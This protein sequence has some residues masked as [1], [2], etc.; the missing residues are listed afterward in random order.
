MKDYELGWAMQYIDKLK[1]K[2]AELEFDPNQ[3]RDENGMWTDTGGGGAAGGAGKYSPDNTVSV[4]RGDLSRKQKADLSKNFGL[5]DKNNEGDDI[6][7]ITNDAGEIEAFAQRDGDQLFFL[8][9]R[10]TGT[11]AGSAIVRKLQGEYDRLTARNVGKSS[12]GFW[13]KM[14]FEQGQSTGER[15]GEY[16]YEWYRD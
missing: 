11:G 7:L 14:G 1:K 4:S 2:L 16:D 13:K 10:H 15:P 3:P 6:D 8:E 9:S 5:W 12:A